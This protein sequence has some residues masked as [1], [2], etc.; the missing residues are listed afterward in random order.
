MKRVIS[1]TACFAFLLFGFQVDAKGFSFKKSKAREEKTKKR[2]IKH[3]VK[4]QRQAKIRSL[5]RRVGRAKHQS[6]LT[7]I[8]EKWK[9]RIDNI[10]QDRANKQRLMAKWKKHR[11]SEI[12]R[13]YN[14]GYFADLYK[15]PAWPAYSNYITSK[16]IFSVGAS[17]KYAVD[18]YV[19]D[20]SSQGVTALAFG[21]EHVLVQDVL[22]ASKLVKA[23][24]LTHKE[25]PDKKAAGQAGSEYLRYFADKEILFNG[26]AE[27]FKFDFD[28]A[29]YI[30]NRNLVFGFNIPVIYIKHDLKASLDLPKDALGL[31]EIETTPGITAP[32]AFMRRYGQDTNKFIADMFSAKGMNE[33]GGSSTGM[34]DLSVYGHVVFRSPAFE[35]S[36]AGLKLTIP[37]AQKA[38][39]GKLWAPE[40]G[41]GGFWQGSLFSST[42][43]NYKTSINP[44]ILL[45]AS[46]ALPGNVLKR[47]PKRTEV[48]IKKWTTTAG[49][50]VIDEARQVPFG[51]R[52]R[53]VETSKIATE[54]FS[55]KISEFD[56]T[57]RNMADN[58]TK[59]TMQKGLECEIK[60]GNVFEK[61]LLRRAFF[62]LFYDLRV[63]GSDTPSGLNTHDWML[64]IYREDTHQI[65]HK[66]G[67]EW[68]YQFDRTSRLKFGSNYTFAGRNVAKT[69]QLAAMMIYSF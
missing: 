37:T 29:R 15:Q 12:N 9:D 38:S 17:Y 14:F 26:K 40:L 39:T 30:W 48:P 28:V 19:T 61:F 16:H 31:V 44:H 57:L 67:C 6:K 49:A 45:Q 21:K 51:D 55:S 41:N 24:T 22:L 5:K 52:V 46:W 1:F 20:G 59:F 66:V 53:Y 18:G 4:K 11:R 3:E 32:N 69:F 33:L 36:L 35:R 34:G 23:K 56:T 42:V 13:Q 2:E 50:P 27:E 65:E 54:S 63:K 68:A 10:R 25:S 43:F 62:D 58:A 47:V 8:Q 7:K 60:V 64:E